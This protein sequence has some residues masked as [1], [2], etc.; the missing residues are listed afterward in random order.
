[1]PCIGVSGSKTQLLMEAGCLEWDRH[2]LIIYINILT[3]NSYHLAQTY[4]AAI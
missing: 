3:L 1:M 4:N 2:T